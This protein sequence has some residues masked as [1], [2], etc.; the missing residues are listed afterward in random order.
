MK[1][2]KSHV[3]KNNQSQSKGKIHEGIVS[4]GGQS[5]SKE[6]DKELLYRSKAK[7]I[8]VGIGAD[9]QMAGYGRHRVT[10][11]KGGYAAVRK[12]LLME[13]SRLWTRNLGRDDRCI[14]S[15]GKEA[16]FPF[17]D[18]DVSTYLNSLDITE[19]VDMTKPEGM[20]DKMILRCIAKQLGVTEC[21]G[22]LKR[23]IQFGSRIAKCSEKDRFGSSRNASG[24]A[25]H[26]RNTRLIFEDS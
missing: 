22:L 18:E 21:S 24:S 15:H 11:N 6:N 3:S 16:R 1:S 26:I 25:S 5:F 2:K 14:S 23:A 20:G 4:P 13:K 7:V 17:L 10:Y 19:I 12:E 9:E 8:I